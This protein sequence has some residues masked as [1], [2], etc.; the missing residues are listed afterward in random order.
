[1]SDEAILQEGRRVIAAESAA[2]QRT[3]QGLDARF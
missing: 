1:M 2:L 3:L